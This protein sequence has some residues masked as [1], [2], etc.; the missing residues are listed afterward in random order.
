MSYIGHTV[1]D[2]GDFFFH[3]EPHF[4]EVDMI[5]L[6]SG[7]FAALRNVGPVIFSGSAMRRQRFR[8]EETFEFGYLANLN[9][10]LSSASSRPEMRVDMVRGVCKVLLA[11]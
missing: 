1:R 7:Q 10:C 8:D 4:T 9:M 11:C 6:T 3:D 5:R 2:S